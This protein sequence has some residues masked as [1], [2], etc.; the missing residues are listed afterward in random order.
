MTGQL[1]PLTI[2]IKKLLIDNNVWFNEFIHEP[3]KTSIEAA[4]VRTGYTLDQGAKA[5]ILRIKVN[6]INKYVML[7]V[8]G[9]AKFDKKKVQI[10]LGSKD[11]RFATV[12]EV[13]EITAGVKIGGVP[14]LGNLFNL[15]VIADPDLFLNEK[16]IYNAGDRSY[17]IAM[18]SKDYLTLVNPLIKK[19]I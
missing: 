2:K 8:P 18:Y 3:V 15:Q 12:D 14:P 4:R 11:I 17:S 10:V 5:L 9:D 19:I 7:V 6:K 1:H 16:I 13:S